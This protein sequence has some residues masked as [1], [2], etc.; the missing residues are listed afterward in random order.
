MVHFSVYAN[1]ILKIKMLT[2]RLLM[3]SCWNDS[4]N[5]NK[6]SMIIN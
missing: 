1:L 2:N 6:L 3:R 5:D 4:Q